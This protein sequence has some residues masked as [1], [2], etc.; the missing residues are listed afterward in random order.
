VYLACDLQCDGAYICTVRRILWQETGLGMQLVE[1]FNYRQRLSENI[2][3]VLKRWDY[4]V[5]VHS[6]IFWRE[7]LAAVSKK[8]N[9][10]ILKRQAFDSKKEFK[11]I[12][13]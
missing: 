4:P 1:I 11:D 6:A 13:S 8:M 3:S 12:F 7:L 2:R 5:W 10:L 9:G